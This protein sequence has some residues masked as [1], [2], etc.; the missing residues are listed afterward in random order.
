MTVTVVAFLV[1]LRRT[2]FAQFVDA[3]GIDSSFVVQT[4]A[5][6][7]LMGLLTFS[8]LMYLLARQGA[9]HRSRRH[10]RVPRA[11]I[12]AHLAES[13]SAVTVLVPSYREDPDVVRMTLLSA[14]LQEFPSI[15]VVPLL[16]DPPQPAD[17]DAAASLAACRALAAEVADYLREPRERLS[18]VLDAHELRG[19]SGGAGSP[20][21]LRALAAEFAWA[22]DWLLM[23]ADEHP[24]STMQEAFVADEVLAALGDDL[25]RTG[26]ALAA[27]AD[28][29]V[30]MSWERLCQLARRLAWTFQAELT[31][32]ERK[33]YAELP[34]EANKAMNLNAYLSLMGG[35]YREVVTRS[36]VVLRPTDDTPDLVVPATPLVLTLD[37]DSVLLREYCLRLAYHLDLPGN[38]RIAVIQTPYSAFRG[39]ITRVER[40]AGATTDLQHQLHQGMTY[41][42]ATFW[43]GANALIRREA[44][45]DI[46]EVSYVDG[47]EERRYIQDRTVIED[48]ESSIDLVARGW[49]LY[50]YAER[51]SYS[52]TPPD[53]GSL[54]VQRGR[55]SNGGLLIIPAYWRYLRRM[56]RDRRKVGLASVALR[57]NYMASVA[58]ASVGLVALLVLPFNSRLLSP[59]LVAAALPYFIAMSSDLHRMGY[60]RTDV[61]RIY[62]FNLVLLP[63][64]LAGVLKSLQQ[65]AAKSKIPFARTPKIRDR[66]ATPALFVL[67][68]VLI[69]AFSFWVLQRDVLERNWGN[70]A[71]AAFNALLTTYAIVAFLGVRNAVQ[72]VLHGAAAWIR[73]PRVERVVTGE[74]PS[75]SDDWEDVLYYGPSSNGDRPR[76]AT[77]TPP[78]SRRGDTRARHRGTDQHSTANG[79]REEVP[80]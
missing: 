79:S 18:C 52:A 71:F 32:F 22:A 61:F 75:T 65:A 60:K 42:D 46:V 59:A 63:V 10:L 45:D 25:R 67:S 37:A 26:V 55:W 77:S 72:D 17:D 34:P 12:D 74:A 6:V 27:A 54:A 48:T 44:L 36:G 49:S 7:V 41:Y 73:V 16:D 50:N 39:A 30:E 40:I 15:R 53:F 76:R 29:G 21:D 80:R 78:M 62:G 64:N 33:R 3:G 38:E 11:E 43:V 19:F 20:D 8:A 23:R 68:A 35:S 56:R 31:T 2:V 4:I 58:W 28:S 24:R 1:Y 57:V 47:I 70:A 13:A 69:A 9:L 14:A 51:L 66:T 5:Y